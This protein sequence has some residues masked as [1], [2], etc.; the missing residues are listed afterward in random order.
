MWIQKLLLPSSTWRPPCTP[1]REQ[2]TYIF[3]LNL[4]LRSRK[5]EI[6]EL[7]KSQ[8][9][10]DFFIF[11][12]V[13]LKNIYCCL[14]IQIRNKC[15]INHINNKN[16]TKKS[17]IQ[18]MSCCYSDDFSLTATTKFCTLNGCSKY[19]WLNIIKNLTLNAFQPCITLWV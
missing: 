2:N 8:G 3:L 6:T 19:I 13:C 17:T 10:T 16:Q 11:W 7:I 5:T 12:F 18:H 9:R 1:C 4:I 14:P 15:K